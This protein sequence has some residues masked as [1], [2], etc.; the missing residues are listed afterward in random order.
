MDLPFGGAGTR[1]GR[2]DPERLLP[3][4]TVDFWR[5]EE[6]EADRRLRLSAEMA[7][8]GR[9]WL[10]FEVEPDGAGSVIRQTAIFDPV[11]VTGRLYWY[12]V[13]PLHG[14]VFRG[15][16][17]RHRPRGG[18]V[19]GASPAAGLAERLVDWMA[20]NR[21]VLDRMMAEEGS[22]AIHEEFILAE[23]GTLPDRQARIERARGASARA[24][25]RHLARGVEDV[26]E[27]AEPGLAERV[28]RWSGASGER[29]EAL[30]L[31]ERAV[32]ERRGRLG[33]PGR[34]PA[35]RGADRPL[36]PLRRGAG[37]PGP[38]PGGPRA[39]RVRP[40]GG[41]AGAGR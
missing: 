11:G 17:P 34:R 33:R 12:T 30:A 22:R 8:P 29:L 39:A 20:I 26:W 14:F 10:Q 28:E 2:R 24:W 6:V 18:G 5:V 37:D 35:R 9:A 32:A 19:S 23:G 25:M 27:G 7:L 1:R 31:E 21:A 36:P 3:G 15:H 13:W 41:G 40:P 16:D 38:G 4:D